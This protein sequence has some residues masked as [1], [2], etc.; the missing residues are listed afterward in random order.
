M[1]RLTFELLVLFWNM[2]S[3]SEWSIYVPGFGEKNLQGTLYLVGGRE[4]GVYTII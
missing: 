1:L 3:D 2:T 4:R